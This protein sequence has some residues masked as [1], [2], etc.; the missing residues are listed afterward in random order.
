MVLA[1]G[2]L[3]WS[4]C[5]VMQMPEQLAET[6]DQVTALEA[7][8]AALAAQVDELRQAERLGQRGVREARADLSAQL[9]EIE[10]HLAAVAELQRD[11]RSRLDRL[12]ARAAEPERIHVATR[13]DTVLIPTILGEQLYDAALSNALQERYPL[14]IQE[15]SD[16]LERFPQGELADDCQYYIGDCYDAQHSFEA[17]AR[18]YL[19]LVK[20]FPASDRVPQALY[21]AG[22]A[23]AE[24]GRVD[25]AQRTL[26]RVVDEYPFTDEAIRARD[27]LRRLH[28]R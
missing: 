17:A 3:L 8:I 26:E 5:A 21:K 7:R 27:A 28:T 10:R 1:L 2:G 16:Y 14:A 23:L 11:S 20:D 24:L 9:D 4:G 15:F 22:A 25:E 6:Q 13:P 19:K 12:Q 18:A